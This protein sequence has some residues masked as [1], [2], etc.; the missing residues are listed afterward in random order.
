MKGAGTMME[1]FEPSKIVVHSNMKGAG[2]FLKRGNKMHV[3]VMWQPANGLHM[4]VIGGYA[5]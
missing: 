1:G 5:S 4:A 3:I 2:D